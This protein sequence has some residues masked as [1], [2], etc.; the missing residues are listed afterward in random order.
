MQNATV[1]ALWKA[2]FPL[3]YFAAAKIS[4]PKKFIC[5]SFAPSTKG[6]TEV[7]NFK[8]LSRRTN[9]FSRE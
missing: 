9:F 6:Q 3:T 4:P 8:Q 1:Y 5:C 7:E 2:R